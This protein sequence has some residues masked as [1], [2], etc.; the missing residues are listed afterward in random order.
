MLLGGLALHCAPVAPRLLPQ[1]KYMGNTAVAGFWKTRTFGF[2][3]RKH[4]A[5][6]FLLP[7]FF[8]QSHTQTM[9]TL[10]LNVF[11]QR[12]ILVWAGSLVWQAGTQPGS[13]PCQSLFFWLY[14]LV[15]SSQ[16]FTSLSIH[17]TLPA[18]P[19]CLALPSFSLSPP[20][21]ASSEQV[22][23]MYQVPGTSVFVG[24]RLTHFSLTTSPGTGQQMH[25][26]EDVG[27]GRLCD[28]PKVTR[29]WV[30]EQWHKPTWA[31]SILLPPHPYIM[32]ASCSPH[33]QT[34][35]RTA[36]WSSGPPVK[37]C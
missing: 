8:C 7:F 2:C 10:I 23:H 15:F 22:Q 26:D 13:L 31:G 6:P 5:F 24:I 27:T 18:L 25:T 1:P 21:S 3:Q 14:M 36:S 30:T 12:E 28:M 11:S 34:S 4:D 29:L 35:T 37:P 32:A 17:A 9:I 16:G 19:L 33:H 20:K